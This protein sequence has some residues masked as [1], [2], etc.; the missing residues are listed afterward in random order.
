MATSRCRETLGSYSNEAQGPD[1]PFLDAYTKSFLAQHG[2]PLVLRYSQA[3]HRLS[4]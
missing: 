3:T 4:C 1:A 2:F